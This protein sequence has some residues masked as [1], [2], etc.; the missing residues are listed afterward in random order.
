MRSQR[1]TKIK[2]MI[3]QEKIKELRRL[4]PAHFARRARNGGGRMH[5]HTRYHVRS[6]RA[7]RAQR[8]FPREQVAFSARDPKATNTRR[9]MRRRNPAPRGSFGIE[10]CVYAADFQASRIRAARII[11]GLSK[12]PFAERSKRRSDCLSRT[13][14]RSAHTPRLRAWP[15]SR[16][17]T[18]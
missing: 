3:S 11:C 16:R 8:R 5:G 12:V 15:S 13:P 10:I 14:A 1:L 4:I 9:D 17:R 18:P 2:H 6:S 7:T